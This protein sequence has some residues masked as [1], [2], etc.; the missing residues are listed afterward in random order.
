MP[1]GIFQRSARAPSRLATPSLSI[2]CIMVLTA[3]TVP[4]DAASFDCRRAGTVP[5]KAI[6][7]DPRLSFL[8]ER[9]NKNYRTLTLL[10]EQAGNYTQSLKAVEERQEKW[11]T[12]RNACGADAFCIANAYGQRLAEIG[13]CYLP[14]QSAKHSGAGP[15][16]E[17]ADLRPA[18]RSAQASACAYRVD[19][20][21]SNK[22]G[23]CGPQWTVVDPRSIGLENKDFHDDKS[24]FDAILLRDRQSGQYL[25]AFRGTDGLT[26]INDWMNNGQ[27]AV[28][29]VAKQYEQARDLAKEL[30]D[31][32]PRNSV[33]ETTG[34]SL[35]G[36]LATTA[37]LQFHAPATV[38]DPAALH[39]R[40]ARK[41]GLNYDEAGRL[42][43]VYAVQGDPLTA[44]QDS[45]LLP[46]PTSPHAMP[47]PL[48]SAPGRRIPLDP[49]PHTAVEGISPWYYHDIDTLLEALR[50]RASGL[51]C[52][53]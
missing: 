34:H 51:G 36:G 45:P 28:G 10:M 41:L 25:L 4:A 35:G 48:P 30:Q 7:A 23:A 43:T 46:L 19:V 13:Y 1:T 8:D 27:Q 53:L 29:L 11:L 22:G 49:P 47:N 24:G 17:C 15:A 18:Y 44:A 16:P 31:K 14:D 37:A 21:M 2:L 50:R 40:V 39:P 26:A 6:C 3:D 33:I 32:L 52:S 20:T 9:L 38:F 5:E 12:E 42:A